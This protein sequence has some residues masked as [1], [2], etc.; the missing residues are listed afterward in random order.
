M[1]YNAL[2]VSGN[3][4]TYYNDLPSLV[5][6]MA[7]A[8]GLEYEYDSHLEGGWSWERHAASQLTMDKIRQDRWDVVI[9]QEYSTRPAYPDEELC[10][11]TLPYLDQLVAAVME[12]NPE[13]VIQFYLTWGRPGGET[14]LCKTMPQFCSYVSYQVGGS[15]LTVSG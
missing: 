12:N 14:E 2:I 15:M 9:L 13:T 1:L 8:D 10:R 5:S 4:F 7:L 11:Q 6:E 3:S